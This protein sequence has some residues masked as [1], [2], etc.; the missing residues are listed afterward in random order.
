MDTSSVVLGLDEA[1]PHRP[2]LL[3]PAAQGHHGLVWGT[4]GSGKSRYL[5]SL[6]LQHLAQGH[7]VCLI[8][9]HG[10]LATLVLSTCARRGFLRRRDAVSRLVYADF[11][12]GHI[13]F[14]VLAGRGDPHARALCA[15]EGMTRTWPDL[16]SAPL[17]ATVFLSAALVLIQNG[18][19]ITELARVL[20]DTS[21]RK[22]V[23]AR[24][25]DP[26]VHQSLAAFDRGGAAQA[27]SALRRSFLLGFSPVARAVLGHAENALDI[28]AM[29]DSGTSLIANLGSIPDPVT[30][31]LVGALLLVQIEQAALSRS[32]IPEGAR[33]PWTCLVD[34]WPTLSA[35]SAE[36]LG[37]I[38]SQSRKYGLR[39]H[40]AAQSIAQVDS[41][42]LA[43]ALENCR[44]ST[45]F[46]LGHASARVRAAQLVAEEPPQAAPRRASDPRPPSTAERVAA[47]TGTLTQL[48]QR[49]A[50][51]QLGDARPVAMTTLHVADDPNGPQLAREAAEVYRIHFARR[52]RARPTPATMLPTD[53]P[54]LDIL[55]QHETDIISDFAAFFGEDIEAV[56][57][58]PT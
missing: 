36:T 8:D 14:N 52:Y 49:R 24:V 22:Q 21:F 40:L 2:I 13:P 54:A 5:A 28:R 34:E 51:V 57:L 29:M 38:L 39:L 15:L 56:Q 32:D 43:G 45:T 17:F 1:D 30:R 10:D 46:R 27:G 3:S 18:L 42:R 19:P 16:K 26:L 11:G 44:L 50:I 20:L 31:R 37:E 33:R 35:T 58:L 12:A 53:E 55:G 7:G 23:L 6:F 41:E 25:S 48:P 47:W 9:P 4:T